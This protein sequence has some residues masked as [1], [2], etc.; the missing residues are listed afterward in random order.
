L[1]QQR[2]QKLLE[3]AAALAR[4]EEQVLATRLIAG[5][6]TSMGQGY[7]PARPV[8]L[9][10]SG[11]ARIAS[12]LD[13]LRRA[14]LDLDA[15]SAVTYQ[16][17]FRLAREIPPDGP[18]GVEAAIVAGDCLMKLGDQRG[19]AAAWSFVA[20]RRPDHAD[21]H[22]H[23]ASISY[24]AGA[25]QRALHHLETLAQLE[26]KDGRPHR[27][28]GYIYKDEKQSRLAIDAYRQ[29]LRRELVPAARAEVVKELAELW[30]G[31]GETDYD[32]A[33]ATLRQC[34][35]EYAETVDLLALRAQALFKSRR[36]ETQAL[37]LVERA[38]QR[39][40]EH[41]DA[42]LV[43]AGMY[44]DVEQPSGAIPLMEA[45]VRQAPHDLR[46][47]IRIAQAYERLASQLGIAAIAFEAERAVPL[48]FG[49]PVMPGNPIPILQV[50]LVQ[51][52]TVQHIRHRD[53]TQKRI[54]TVSRLSREASERTAD[55]RVRCQLARLWLEMENP[56]LAR[57]WFRAALTCNPQNVEARQGL[58]ELDSAPSR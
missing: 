58:L 48:A 31:E 2:A 53:A 21:A 10:A 26:P 32:E 50:G 9:G 8:S 56:R 38:L 5:V 28:M 42:L 46:A 49:A 25:T 54:E 1:T 47:R 19:A 45:A 55:D 27:L 40:P 11:F 15:Q 43:R 7:A 33:L 23:L 41:L 24:D 30:L 34:P 20:E 3:Q 29:A 37:A 36:D 22:R 35:P 4:A 13:S 39:D 14:R 16:E 51:P 44:L 6:L 12:R 18:L 57:L 17:A 52:R